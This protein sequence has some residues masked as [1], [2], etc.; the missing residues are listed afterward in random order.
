MVNE[1]YF[2]KD[3]GLFYSQM[4]TNVPFPAEYNRKHYDW[5]KVLKHI[6]Y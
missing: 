5:F 3:S 2:G 4:K 6:G 1:K